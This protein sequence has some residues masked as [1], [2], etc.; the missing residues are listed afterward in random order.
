MRGYLVG[1][2][3]MAVAVGLTVLLVVRVRRQRRWRRDVA[4]QGPVRAAFRVP[5]GRWHPCDGPQRVYAAGRA[6]VPRPR[7]G[8]RG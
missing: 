7:D 8:G 5:Q 1:A 3:L 2:L 4:V 6:R